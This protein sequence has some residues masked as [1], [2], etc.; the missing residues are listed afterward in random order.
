MTK[1]EKPSHQP[2]LFY[3]AAQKAIKAGKIKG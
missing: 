1:D 3:E 2:G